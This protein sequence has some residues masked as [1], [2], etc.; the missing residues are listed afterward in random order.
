MI[1]R[2]LAMLTLQRSKVEWGAGVEG[3]CRV[4]FTVLLALNVHHVLKLNGFRHH[5][6]KLNGFRVGDDVTFILKYALP[7]IVFLNR[8]RLIEKDCLLLS[9]YWYHKCWIGSDDKFLRLFFITDERPSSLKRLFVSL[10]QTIH[11]IRLY[12]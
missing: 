12:E 6:L 1:I 2:Y 9:E 5:V 8:N 10:Y 4:L 11:F 3:G 7:D